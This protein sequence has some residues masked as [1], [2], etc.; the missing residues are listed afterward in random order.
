MSCSIHMLLLIPRV[1]RG[2]KTNVG[3]KSRVAGRRVR[4]HLHASIGVFEGCGVDMIK[5]TGVVIMD[6]YI[7]LPVMILGEELLRALEIS[8]GWL[9]GR[10]GR[11]YQL[12][13]RRAVRILACRTVDI[14]AP[15]MCLVVSHIEIPFREGI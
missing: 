14:G 4:I 11:A 9:I 6:G 15:S 7:V 13:D 1:Q 8:T 3:G 10:A 2:V 12:I 5:G